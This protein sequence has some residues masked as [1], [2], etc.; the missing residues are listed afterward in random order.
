MD[1]RDELAAM[2]WSEEDVD[3]FLDPARPSWA[4]FDA[5]TGYVPSDI[6]I[7]DGVDDSFTIN[8]YEDLGA[9]ATTDPRHRPVAR[10]TVRYRE[11]PCRI[12]TYGDSFTQCHQVSDGETWQE[13]LAAHLGEPIRNFGVGGFG[14][15]QAFCRMRAIEPASHGADYVVLN[16]FDDDH[17]RNL[18]TARWFR[19]GA[20][21]TALGD[22]IQPML[23]AN[24]WAHLRLDPAS[25]TFVEVPNPLPTEASLRAFADPVAV[26]AAYAD[27]PVVMLDALSRGIA[28]GDV[29]PLEALA[30][31][32]GLATDLRTGDV[33]TAA[34][35][36]LT[37]IGL[38]ATLATLAM[39]RAFVA[40]QGKQLLVLL[41]YS[42]D[43]VVEALEGRPR[44][45]QLLVDD[46]VS[47]RDLFVDGLEAHRRD[48]SAFALP[49]DR[50]CDRYYNGHYTPS[51]NHFFAFA[52]KGALVRWLDPAPVSYGG[53]GPAVG[54]A[55][56]TLA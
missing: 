27:D 13:V 46:L 53:Q 39:V 6:V 28:V 7:R 19:V 35:D 52:V 31:A 17:V 5:L 55:A 14:V 54:P 15:Y 48:A 23:H 18:D 32:T 11:N 36:L 20:F 24:P 9:G 3:Y 4:R 50:Y 38:R 34:A 1:I 8:S 40:E 30:A 37:A 2:T 47:H 10:R 33:A 42:A 44:F 56:G 51:G 49:A 22:D 29:G 26:V 21:A 25:G 41:S 45:D 43:S 12:N 16:I